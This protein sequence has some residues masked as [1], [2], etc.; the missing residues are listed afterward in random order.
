MVQF[1]AAPNT[2]DAQPCFDEALLDRIGVDLTR[3]NQD[4]RATLDQEGACVR[5]GPAIPEASVSFD[6]NDCGST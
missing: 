3:L 4:I 1:K 5:L 6:F 2:V